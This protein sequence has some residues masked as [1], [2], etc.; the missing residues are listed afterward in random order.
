MRFRQCSVSHLQMR[1][2][3]PVQLVGTRRVSSSLVT[4]LE[5]W[6]QQPRQILRQR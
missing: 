3:F 6:S 1:S 4:V 5:D 2:G